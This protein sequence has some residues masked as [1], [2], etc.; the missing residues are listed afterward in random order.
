MH[1]TRA[2]AR[3]GA[4]GDMGWPD[5][6][7]RSSSG[8]GKHMGGRSGP[9]P[10]SDQAG[11]A[12]TGLRQAGHIGYGQ[13]V[14]SRRAPP[15][16]GRDSVET[17]SGSGPGQPGQTLDRPPDTSGRAIRPGRTYARGLSPEPQ[18]T[19]PHIT[20]SS[21][22]LPLRQPI[23][24]SV[25]PRSLASLSA[26]YWFPTSYRFP[27]VGRKGERYGSPPRGSLLHRPGLLVP[28]VPGL[29]GN[30]YLGTS[31]SALAEHLF[32]PPGRP[33]WAQAYWFPNGGNQFRNQ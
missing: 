21:R 20:P 6:S 7:R 16:L 28:L 10:A 30:Q 17:R 14:E 27:T 11:S 3:A 8:P 1:Q 33:I 22:S 23:W 2:R 25:Q 29:S 5:R 13:D 26:L 15:R 12:P 18:T 31:R 4:G 32:T 9:R 19:S 24:A